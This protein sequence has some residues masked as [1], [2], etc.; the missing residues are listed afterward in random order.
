[1]YKIIRQSFA[2]IMLV[3]LQQA[4]QAAASSDAGTG[5]I[6]VFVEGG[7]SA[8]NFPFLPLTGGNLS[9]I[10]PDTG[11]VFSGTS[12]S[13]MTNFDPAGTYLPDGSIEYAKNV[14]PELK[15]SLDRWALWF[16]REIKLLPSGRK[17]HISPL[18]GYF[19]AQHI[20]ARIEI[21][22]EVA[23]ALPKEELIK[24]IT[25]KQMQAYRTLLQS[26]MLLGLCPGDLHGSFFWYQM[27][28]IPALSVSDRAI[29]THGLSSIN[30][31][32][33]GFNDRIMDAFPETLLV[34]AAP[35][36]TPATREG[37]AQLLKIFF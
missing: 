17:K 21:G 32:L 26:Q 27:K 33:N 22:N 15:R 37:C 8:F 24:Q 31:Q 28:G 13:S 36:E 16:T 20:L 25:P 1:M 11:V 2:M 14:K 9:Y 5:L 35:T 19:A 10:D 18:I 7:A 23:E 6:S 12:A 30:E 34:A 4:V 3:T 29:G